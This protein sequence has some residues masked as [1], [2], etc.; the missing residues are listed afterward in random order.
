MLILGLVLCF[1][2][3]LGISRMLTLGW[4]VRPLYTLTRAELSAGPEL[5]PIPLLPGKLLHSCPLLAEN[6]LLL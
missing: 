2:M 6:F 4:W 3:V 5:S 1:E